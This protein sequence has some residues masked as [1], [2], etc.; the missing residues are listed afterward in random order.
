MLEFGLTASGFVENIKN[1]DSKDFFRAIEE[2]KVHLIS[3]DEIRM[4]AQEIRN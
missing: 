1:F 2:L 3:L 4:F